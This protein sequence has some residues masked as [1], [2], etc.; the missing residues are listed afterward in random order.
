MAS[1]SAYPWH[2]DPK[3]WNS[4]SQEERFWSRVTKN[5]EPDGCWW[6]RGGS[7]IYWAD[8]RGGKTAI[9][10]RRL[11]YQLITGEDAPDGRMF[12]TCGQ[13]QCINPDHAYVPEP[14]EKHEDRRKRGSAHWNT[15]LTE[16][17]VKFM[18]RAI[19][20]KTETPES[21]A[22]Q[23]DIALSTVYQII[24]GKTWQHVTDD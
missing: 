9:T 17:D 2:V 19:K 23:H 3:G 7:S 11:A 14:P 18:R 24:T 13:V 12:T 1:K 4:K 16:R 21:L 22:E 20:N 8:A 10:P 6:W 5:A 15:K